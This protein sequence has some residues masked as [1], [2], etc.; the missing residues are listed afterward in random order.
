ML[1]LTECVNAFHKLLNISPQTPWTEADDELKQIG[2]KLISLSKQL[3]ERVA[4]GD[5]PA[6]RAHLGLEEFG[7]FLLAE[8][9]AKALDGWADRLY[10]LLGDCLVYD[11]PDEQAFAEAHRSNMT[12]QK[13]ADDELKQRVR[14][15]GAAFE[16]PDF[17]GVLSR[18]REG[19]AD[20]LRQ[21]TTEDFARILHQ[22][23]MRD[24]IVVD[25]ELPENERRLLEDAAAALTYGEKSHAVAVGHLT[26]I[27][28]A[29]QNEITLKQR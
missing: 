19:K 26:K 2:H 9:E 22:R 1:L 12:K 15:K 7:E 10:V 20:Q 3:E 18:H 13:S 28:E 6:L 14:D 23:F 24:R 17:A 27:V 16:P 11:W 29:Y 4:S 25:S 21:R 5:V 8:T